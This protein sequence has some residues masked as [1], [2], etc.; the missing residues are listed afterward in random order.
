LGSWRTGGET[1]FLYECRTTMRGSTGTELV[2]LGTGQG[3]GL[4]ERVGPPP[5][6]T[7][8]AWTRMTKATIP[9]LSMVL[10]RRFADRATFR[11]ASTSLL[12]KEHSPRRNSTYASTV[13]LLSAVLQ[14][15]VI[16]G[17][18]RLALAIHHDEAPKRQPA[19]TLGLLDQSHPVAHREHHGDD[20]GIVPHVL[21][22]R[23]DRLRRIVSVGLDHAP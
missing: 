5:P 18:T 19:L 8:L 9:R 12:C 14:G 20:P 7:T 6:R 10:R 1:S 2:A 23:L 22:E 15:S 4:V 21:V 11:T 16:G 17:L 3:A 13:T